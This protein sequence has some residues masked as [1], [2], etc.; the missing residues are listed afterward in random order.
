M[1]ST[2]NAFDN[3]QN[4]NAFAVKHEN[5]G[6]DANRGYGAPPAPSAF[7]SS[8]RT[9]QERLLR[10]KLLG[11]M[12]VLLGV[13]TA[14]FC[15]FAFAFNAIMVPRIADEVVT[16]FA[17][18]QYVDAEN[19]GT[20]D[21]SAF[22]LAAQATR[23]DTIVGYVTDL[24][25]SSD[26]EG[27]PRENA[28]KEALA[29]A[30]KV[31]ESHP[32]NNGSEIRTPSDD[33][34]Y[35][36]YDVS[37]E[38]HRAIEDAVG[39]LMQSDSA[40]FDRLCN[41]ALAYYGMTESTTPID[42]FGGYYDTYYLDGHY[43]YRDMSVYDLVKSFKIPLAVGAFL[44]GVVIIMWALLRRSLDAFDTLFGA[45]EGVLLKRDA[46]PDLPRELE[47]TSR[48][49]EAIAREN[50]SNEL[51]A[52]AAEQRKNELVAYLAHDIRTPLTSV[53]G[54]LTMLQ[55]SP[56]MPIE[57]RARY[58][59]IALDRAQRLEDMLEEF[60]EITRYNLQSIPIE[61]ERFDVGMLCR[62]VTDEFFPI[63]ES[64]GIS[65]EVD[66]ATPLAAFADPGK[67]SRVLNNLL[68]N[69]VSYANEGSTVQV[70]AR[71]DDGARA[72]DGAR[73][74]AGSLNLGMP[75]QESPT[76]ATA[77]GAPSGAAFVEPFCAAT[78]SAR[79]LTIEVVNQ[80]REISPAHLQSIF[81]KFYREDTSRS[82]QAG[83]AGLGL[84]IA[85]EIARAHGGDLS[86]S[87]ESGVTTFTLRIPA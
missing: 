34:L 86:A 15:L 67:V 14:A 35:V 68:K 70:R 61:R 41:E 38:A 36:F 31:R 22:Q 18:I 49:L 8:Y 78:T 44:V 24:Y 59:G 80:G 45:M 76:N 4:G 66:A 72:S 69:A 60:F 50:E 28:S 5:D 7:R 33:T 65:I 47:P 54:Y 19:A 52:R 62:Q 58:A 42:G 30:D 51:A 77:Q 21:W 11:R 29:I 64:R 84:A 74:G 26:G 57:Q 75:R 16:R 13:W 9:E 6:F 85:R 87:S 37:D 10:R 63:A 17:P 48:A 82:T 46:R 23:K 1:N 40:A 39:F 81:E 27:S 56:D 43:E 53:V 79:W 32:V 3:G 83:G 71:I 12:F 73:S 25:G 55:E 2:T 20:A